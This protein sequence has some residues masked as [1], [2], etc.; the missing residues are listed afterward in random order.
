MKNHFNAKMGFGTSNLAPNMRTEEW[1][2]G[3]DA[4]HYAIEIGYTVLDTAEQYG[5]GKSEL[6]IGEVLSENKNRD[7]LH[8][9]SK[10]LPKNAL[11][12]DSII[13]ACVNSIRRMNC[14]YI[15]TYLLH[16][17]DPK[18]LA[19]EP[20]I[21]AFVKLK[22]QNLIKNYGVSNFNKRYLIEWQQTEKALG[23][24]DS[25]VTNQTHYSISERDPERY[26]LDWQREHN[27]TTMAY[28]PLNDKRNNLLN[29]PAY[30]SIA[31]RHGYDPTQLALAWIIQRDDVITIPTS[32]NLHHIESNFQS[33]FI[34]LSA[35]VLQD[36]D[37]EFK[38]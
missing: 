20:I 30:I 13:N 6:I 33:Q 22:D 29:N 14:D 7:T 26:Y 8:I 16:W 1:R 27:I 12:V 34:T 17:R 9:V 31:D 37:T 36:I 32:R 25:V 2:R 3:K 28:S 35:E 4:L 11:T 18:E 5:D 23:V 21:E 38:L 19:F 24:I 10:V 15:D